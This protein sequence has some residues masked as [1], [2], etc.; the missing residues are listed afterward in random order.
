MYKKLNLYSRI[1]LLLLLCGISKFTSAD[2]QDVASINII[3]ESAELEVGESLSLSLRIEPSDAH[4]EIV[5]FSGDESIA[6]VTSN[7]VVTALSPGLAIIYAK[8]TDGV[9]GFATIKVKDNRI[10]SI[11]VTPEKLIL[12][13]GETARL[14]AQVNPSAATTQITWSSHDPSIAEVD[15]QGLVKAMGKGTTF[16]FAKS[17][18]GVAGVA[19]VTVID[20]KEVL[21]IT[22]FPESLELLIGQESQLEVTLQPTTSSQ[23]IIWI[24]SDTSIA[25]VNENGVVAGIN[26]GVTVVYAM[27][28]NGMTGF[29][30]VRVMSNEVTSIIIDPDNL[31]LELDETSQLTLILEPVSAEAEFITWTSTDPTVATVD[32]LGVVTAKET[33]FSFIYATSDNGV[34][35]LAI[36]KVVDPNAEDYDPDHGYGENGA[37]V[38]TYRIREGDNLGLYAE[39][40]RGYE[41]NDW[42]YN[43]YLNGVLEAD[44]KYVLVTAGEDSGWQGNDKATITE[45]YQV[46]IINSIG[47]ELILDLPKVSVYSRP[48]TPVELLKKGDGA[49]YSFIALSQFTDTELESLGYYFVF[50]YTDGGGVNHV[51]SNSPLRY[52]HTTREIYDNPQYRFWVYT[53]W[54]FPDGAS[55]TSGLRYLDG[56]LDENF[57]RSDFNISRSSYVDSMEN[58]S[59]KAIYTLSG[60]FVGKDVSPLAPGFYIIFE[61]K[62][63]NHTTRKIIK[64]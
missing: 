4:E 27:A 41:N 16:I 54:V 36:V 55:I 49:S 37:F 32:N 64:R 1:M 22:V 18:T 45:N 3:P 52:C 58:D 2:A 15:G 19:T 38:S 46:D 34:T 28:E 30:T 24:S 39:R 20:S 5:W 26:P 8:D 14:Q 47:D 50:G 62:G 29:S 56:T 40:P 61:R 11:D 31:T 10:V 33:G 12:E 44:G 7:G 13:L 48:L 63:N 42:T 51:I 43:W 23:E 21:S 25:E 6:S 9:T 17:E 35:G 53:S 60:N 57:D 59:E